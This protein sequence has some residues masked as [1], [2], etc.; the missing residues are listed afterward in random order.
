MMRRQRVVSV[1]VCCG[2]CHWRIL[3]R[4][5]D[6]SLYILTVDTHGGTGE[7]SDGSLLSSVLE[8]MLAM[9]SGGV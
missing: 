4:C 9:F 6:P 3:A 8:S 1:F 2:G 5:G 7:D